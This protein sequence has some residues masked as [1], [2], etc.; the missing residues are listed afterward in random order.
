MRMIEFLANDLIPLLLVIGVGIAILLWV[1]AKYFHT[2]KLTTA[3]AV[4]VACVC[5]GLALVIAGVLPLAGLQRSDEASYFYA[6]S[7]VLLLLYSLRLLWPLLS[8]RRS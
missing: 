6:F 3:N 7:G 5:T 2:T 1:L 8:R 4:G